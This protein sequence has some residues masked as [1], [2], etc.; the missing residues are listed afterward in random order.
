MPKH[1]DHEEVN[2]GPDEKLDH[3]G[4]DGDS[5]RVLQGEQTLPTAVHSLGTVLRHSL[6]TYLSRAKTHKNAQNIHF[7]FDGFIHTM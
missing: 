3:S 2:E 4:G 6:S 5:Q 7:L 1:E